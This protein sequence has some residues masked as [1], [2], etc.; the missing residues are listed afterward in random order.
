VLLHQTVEHRRVRLPRQVRRREAGHL[1]A[2]A[3][4]VPSGPLRICSSFPR[5]PWPGPD[6]AG[7]RASSGGYEARCAAHLRRIR[8]LMEAPR[9]LPSGRRV[10]EVRA[11][12][13]EADA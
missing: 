6:R 12:G 5:V 1:R 13:R 8:P 9:R 7:R 4:A 10:A 3:H 11:H 2:V